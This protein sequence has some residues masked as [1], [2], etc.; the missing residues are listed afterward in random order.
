MV[1][2]VA[3]VSFWH[4]FM[5]FHCVRT[6]SFPV[7]FFFKWYAMM[8]KDKSLAQLDKSNHIVTIK[9]HTQVFTWCEQYP[10][11]PKLQDFLAAPI[12]S[13]EFGSPLE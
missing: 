2:S 12:N 10:Q 3:L 13:M 6:L 4:A 8:A 9:C 7:A 1:K 5:K 11:L